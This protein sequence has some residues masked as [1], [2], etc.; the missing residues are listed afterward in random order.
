MSDDDPFE[1]MEDREGDPFE[2]L[3]DPV[4]EESPTPEPDGDDE[5]T[6]G[7]DDT[8]TFEEEFIDDD[9]F[10]VGGESV[11]G[12]PQTSADSAV[13]DG[14]SFD[15]DPFGEMAEDD[16]FREMD[17]SDSDPF[18]GAESAFEAVDVDALDEEEL[19]EAIESDDT[20]ATAQH[21]RYSEVS[22]HRFCEQCEFFAEPPASHCTHE[23][24]SILEYLDM[25]RVRVVN[26]PIVAEQ[27]RIENEE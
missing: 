9:P 3:G 25:E 13:E 11:A 10:S 7:D 19:W 12:E 23:E 4:D 22:K 5:A 18:G 6:V 17:G 16:P 24:A 14:E 2:H 27:R 15:T 20:T 26:C 8:P 21:K 1:S